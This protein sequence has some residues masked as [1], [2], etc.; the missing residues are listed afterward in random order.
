M[1]HP[2]QH[3]IVTRSRDPLHDHQGEV[4]DD[5]TRFDATDKALRAF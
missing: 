3:G 4:N 5:E 1:G 2:A